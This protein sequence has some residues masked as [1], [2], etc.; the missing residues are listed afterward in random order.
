MKRLRISVQIALSLAMLSGTV[1]LLAKPLGLLPDHRR[2]AVRTRITVCENL[3]V[4][5]SL[6]T[7]QQQWEAVA[8]CLR[9]LKVRNADVVSVGLRRQDGRLVAQAGEHQN[10]WKETPDGR[11][12]ETQ[13]YVPIL[14]GKSRWGS[15]EV[16]FLPP[17]TP[18]WPSWFDPAEW[19]L[20][21]FIAAANA[22][23]F[24]C[25]LR[26]VLYDL[27]PSRVMPQR[28]RSALDALTEGLLVLDNEGRIVMANHAFASA[29]GRTPETLLG[30]QASILPWKETSDGQPR[31]WDEVR[32]NKD[33]C[34]GVEMALQDGT[35]A[36]RT[37]LV[38]A[39]PIEDAQGQP[40]GVLASFADITQL[41]QKKQE[42]L[43][44]LE[45]LRESRDKIRQQND[46]LSF[47]A[48][49][50]SLTGCL[51][52]RSFS[53]QFERLWRQG[54]QFELSCIMADIDKFKTIN[55]TFGH[56]S[57]DEVL[58]GVARVLLESIG[59]AG[60]VCRYGG[61]EFCIVLANCSPEHAP[62]VAEI[63]RSKV[64]ALDF[65]QLKVTSSFGVS[66]GVFGATSC[67]EL[68]D[69]ADRSLYFSK[70]NGRNRVS[71]WDKLPQD[72]ASHKLEE[73][74]GTAS[75]GVL[76]KHEPAVPYHA[77]ASL[78]CALA[79]RDPDTA[80]HSA[81]VADL[82]VAT[83]RGLM[84]AGEAYLLEIGALLHDIGKIGVPDSIL[85]KPGPL[86]A[87][88]WE[89]M[90]LHGRIGVEIVNASFHAP[91]LVD[92][93]RFHHAKY[94]SQEPGMPMGKEIPLSA[95]IVCIADAYDAMVSDRVYRKG[96]TP[97]AAFAELRR[98]AGIQFDPELVERFVDTVN[99]RPRGT[100]TAS[101]PLSK[102]LALH[103]GLQTERLATALDDRDYKTIQAL[104]MHLKATAEAHGLAPLAEA[105]DLLQECEG[106]C[107]LPQMVNVIH[108]IIDLS[109]SAQQAYLAIN[110]DMAQVAMARAQFPTCSAE[111]IDLSSA[112]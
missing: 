46:E 12:S 42:L 93:V 16:E 88:E 110:A 70:H 34:S 27:D 6:L 65:P 11:S 77:V 9:E 4:A 53:E 30:T 32:K 94:G 89:I 40:R 73:P 97:E 7:S 72:F 98:M 5:S 36:P 19:R 8:I 1:L 101:G 47:L 49:R 56:S 90:Q 22:L 87:D 35:S 91:S 78:M 95:R 38:N 37:F 2:L 15:L 80:C 17:G 81:R 69:Q 96:R 44:M 24:I 64:A 50:D 99:S 104:S 52:R 10:T 45:A 74:S 28:V 109:L 55:D 54:D 20:I 106:D 29:L 84:S 103:L 63:L 92:I 31:P 39:A 102:D 112:G 111:P 108:Q 71:C 58:R 59:E 60:L 85:L 13:I 18:G 43:K 26:R 41:E 79:Y 68:L 57:G 76:S 14:Q 83:A 66:S 23:I 105:A 51:N 33:V 25:Y 48:T 3:A 100:L 62:E 82:A 107:D 61:E 75:A 67:Q 21:A 86:T